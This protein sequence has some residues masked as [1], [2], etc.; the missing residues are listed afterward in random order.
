MVHHLCLCRCHA[1]FSLLLL[2]EIFPRHAFR[3]ERCNA[4]CMP[5]RAV[6]AHINCAIAGV[7]DS[8]AIRIRRVPLLLHRLVLLILPHLDFCTRSWSVALQATNMRASCVLRTILAC[9]MVQAGN[10]SEYNS[11]LTSRAD[12]HSET[13][14]HPP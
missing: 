1:G 8:L 10:C 4:C 11:C 14:L 13:L 12:T 7:R 9:I 5:L 3:R 2:F 6:E